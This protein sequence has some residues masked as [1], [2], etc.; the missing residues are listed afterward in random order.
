[1]ASVDNVY[2]IAP[3]NK[4]VASSGQTVF[5]Y[6]FPIFDAVDLRVY[7]GDVLQSI[8]TDYTVQG[9]GN[10]NGGTVTFLVGR[11]AGTQV[12][13]YRLMP[14][15]RLT[16]M[17]Q[18]GPM[19]A[20]DFNQELDRITMYL[21]EVRRDMDRSLR[22][23][24]I[25]N[26]P[27]PELSP[28][29][30]WKDRYLYVNSSG[31]LQPAVNIG[32]TPLSQSVIGELLYP[33]SSEE[34][35]AGI[36]PANQA[37]PVGNVLRYGADP[38]GSVDSTA[39]I[40]SAIDVGGAVFFPEGTYLASGLVSA[41][42]FQ[43]F[44]ALGEVRIHKNANGPILTVDE[45]DSFF[46]RIIFDG[47]APTYTG[48]NLVINGDN[49]TL[50]N[51]ASRYADGR[52]VLSTSS[53]GIRIIGTCDIYHTADQSS[54]GYDIELRGAG[55]YSRIIGITSSQHTGGVLID[56]A[57]TVSIVASQFGKLTVI[58]NGFCF[59][60]SSRIHTISIGGANCTFSGNAIASSVDIGPGGVAIGGIEWSAT[61]VLPGGAPFNVGS[62]VRDSVINLE[63]MQETGAVITVHPTAAGMNYITGR[64]EVYSP[65]FT[66]ANADASLGNGVFQTALMARKGRSVRVDISLLVG[67]TTSFGTGVLRIGLPTSVGG[68]SVVGSGMAYDSAGTPYSVVPLAASGTDYV[69]FGIPLV[70]NEANASTP[71]S[72]KSG[73]RLRFS[74]EYPV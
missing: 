58:N 19:R 53:F 30:N 54:S 52:A 26:S 67:S 34:T 20:A 15:E 60:N 18:N 16:D 55:Q 56:E 13:I 11:V 70:G 24:I 61:N 49:C 31:A 42:R 17:A 63:S 28:I 14:I 2:D 44:I 66:S 71:F 40:Q 73:D 27:S 45:R 57:G 38:T 5:D 72:W 25:G 64:N 74:I 47:I 62:G 9:E 69:T 8:G 23:G 35:S 21:Q 32:T 6:D 50:M 51:C 36:I 1:M 4:Y 12:T 59:V 46:E 39:A 22:F 65:A 7:V 3:I 37:F 10:E 29:D 41:T 33:V 48:D 43:N 68:Y